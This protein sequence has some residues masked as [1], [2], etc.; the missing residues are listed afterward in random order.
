MGTEKALLA[1]FAALIGWII[2]T[3][4]QGC[5]YAPGSAISPAHN[6]QCSE[7]LLKEVRDA[8]LTK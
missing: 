4:F 2:V 7:A 5:T 8:C 1:A 6:Y 3:S